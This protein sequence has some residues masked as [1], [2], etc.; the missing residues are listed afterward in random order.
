MFSLPNLQLLLHDSTL[1]TFKKRRKVN[2]KI[3]KLSIFVRKTVRQLKGDGCAN[4][5]NGLHQ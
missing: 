5:T 1:M 3:P 4:V 2:F